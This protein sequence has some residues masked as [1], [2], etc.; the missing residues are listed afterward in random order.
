[1]NEDNSSLNETKPES[2]SAANRETTNKS[3]HDSNNNKNR[4]ATE[5]AKKPSNE[6][7]DGQNNEQDAAKSKE[8]FNFEDFLK[9]DS[10]SDLLTVISLDSYFTFKVHYSNVN[11]LQYS[12]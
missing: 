6:S 4:E 1:M 8:N 10:I 7:D 11:C 12:D 3:S 9:L 5:K 2:K